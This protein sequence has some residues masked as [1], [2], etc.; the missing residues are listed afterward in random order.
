M[1]DPATGWIATANS[2]IADA[3]YPHYLGLD[4]VPDFRTRRIVARLRDLRGATV[5][6]MAAIHADRVSIPARAL[7]EVARRIEPLDAGSRAALA[8]LREWDGAMDQDSAAATLYAAFRA[9]LLRDLLGP[10]ARSAWPATPSRRCRGAAIDAHGAP[11]GRLAEWIRED[12]RT[13]L[14]A[15]DDWSSAMARA[16]AGAV[17]LAPRDARPGPRGLGLGP[18][19]RDPAGASAL[20]VVPRPRRPPRPALPAGRAATA[21][22]CRPRTSSRR[23]DTS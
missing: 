7:V 19:P 17:G 3:D 2:R 8:L 10:A 12:D 15:G 4:Y 9:R 16:L 13:L 14:A 18:A 20:R 5:A 23:R 1:R 6:D 22:R 11:A 21:T